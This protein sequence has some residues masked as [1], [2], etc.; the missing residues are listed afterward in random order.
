[1]SESK[2]GRD[3][4]D[5]GSVMVLKSDAVPGQAVPGQ[6][7]AGAFSSLPLLFGFRS[8]AFEVRVYFQ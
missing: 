1:M 8:E 4:D 7:V 5:G 2:I 6:A 3:R